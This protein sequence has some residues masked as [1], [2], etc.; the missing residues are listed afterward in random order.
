MRKALVLVA[1]IATLTSGCRYSK[2]Y[3]KLTE[4][5]SKYTTAVD[6]L[7][8][9]AGELQLESSSEQILQDDRSVNQTIRDYR[10]ISTQDQKLLAT[11]NDIRSH[12]QLLQAYFNKLEEL[13]TSDAPSEAEQEIADISNNINSISLKIRKSSFF[14]SRSQGI[15]R[16]VTNLAVHSRIKGALRKELKKRNQ[17]ILREL[18]LQREML[19][20]IG[21][22]MTHRVE[23]MKQARE[24]RLVIRPLTAEKPINN[25]DQW[26]NERKR[27]FFMD[28]QVKELTNASEALNEFKDIFQA[29]VEGKINSQRLNNSL[30]DIDSFLA[31]LENNKKSII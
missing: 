28:R 8:V 19:K 16:G 24:I 2:Q 12:N 3:E 14:S 18:T 17:T 29:S 20:E 13:A 6:E 10:N 5:G 25:E 15:L 4:A 1:V 9:I 30:R 26:I 31:L 22:F 7:L 21:G 23:L 11:I 27:I